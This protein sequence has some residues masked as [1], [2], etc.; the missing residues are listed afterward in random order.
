M[1]SSLLTVFVFYIFFVLMQKLLNL[2]EPVAEPLASATKSFMIYEHEGILSYRS[3]MN[4]I[5]TSK[6]SFAKGDIDTTLLSLLKVC[7]F[8]IQYGIVG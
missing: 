2:W 4:L 7:F 1:S 8:M 6:C 3:T 5:A